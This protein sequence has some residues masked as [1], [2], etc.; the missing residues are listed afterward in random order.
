MTSAQHYE[1]ARNL[2]IARQA[3]RK[4]V[5]V[6]K[7]GSPALASLESVWDRLRRRHD[8]DFPDV[9]ISPYAVDWRRS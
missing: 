3:L 4:V 1:C 5:A 8:A 2:L 9:K 6:C 7:M